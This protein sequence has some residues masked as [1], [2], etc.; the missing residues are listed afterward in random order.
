M[1][2]IGEYL[3]GD[4]VETQSG[5]DPRDQRK[6]PWI[7]EGQD[8]DLQAVSLLGFEQRQDGLL[9]GYAGQRAQVLRDLLFREVVEVA[10]LQPA[11]M[12]ADELP[13]DLRAEGA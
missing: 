4:D 6:L 11:Q 7:V 10:V 2:A 5:Q 13:V 9:S 8:G 3:A 1:P 12:L